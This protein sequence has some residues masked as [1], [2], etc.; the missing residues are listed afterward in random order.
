VLQLAAVPRRAHRCS[1]YVVFRGGNIHLD[2]V[3]ALIY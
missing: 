3:G 2:G 1:E